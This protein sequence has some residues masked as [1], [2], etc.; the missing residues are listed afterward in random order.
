MIWEK[1]WF[2]FAIL[3]VLAFVWGSSFILMK[4]GLKSFSPEQAGALRILLA[5]LVLFPISISQ[6]K[7]LQK[8]DLKSLLIT[9]FAIMWGV[10]VGEKVTLLHLVCMT[11]I[12]AGVTSSVEKAA[13]QHWY[14]RVCE[15]TK[16][17]QVPISIV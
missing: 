4:I 17:Q 13:N 1:R 2:Q 3:M 15:L 14:K 7:N 9:G 16:K 8:K 6:L 10:F 11:I 5:S 12:M